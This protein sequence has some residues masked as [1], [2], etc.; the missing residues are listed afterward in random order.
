MT[1][2]AFQLAN[3]T[4]YTSQYL[5]ATSVTV[6]TT[7][8]HIPGTFNATDPLNLVTTNDQISVA[9]TAYHDGARHASTNAYV[10]LPLAPHPFSSMPSRLPQKH[11]R[12]DEPLL[13]R[14]R[15]HRRALRA[16]TRRHE[17]RARLRC[18]RASA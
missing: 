3:I 13:K 18:A 15:A 9:V 4:A 16:H 5:A 14:P 1:C 10:S 8:A 17:Q 12:A 2:S 7:N 6:I 11:L